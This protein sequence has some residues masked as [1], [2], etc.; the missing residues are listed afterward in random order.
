MSDTIQTTTR[1][2]EDIFSLSL[3][4]HSTGIFEDTFEPVKRFVICV[5]DLDTDATKPLPIR[6]MQLMELAS[7]DPKI[8]WTFELAS[9]NHHR[10][11]VSSNSSKSCLN[12][13]K[14]MTP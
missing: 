13:I 7:T 5:Q 12:V 14:A 8:G 11:L 6:H 10:A 3:F 1:R 9:I 2:R 4:S